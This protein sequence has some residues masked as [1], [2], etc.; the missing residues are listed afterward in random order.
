MNHFTAI[1][2]LNSMKMVTDGNLMQTIVNLVEETTNIEISGEE[3]KR[4]VIQRLK[5]VG[6]E[7][8]PIVAAT[9]GY[10]LNL[11]VEVAVAYIK[12]RAED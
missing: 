8:K 5:A 6:G 7:L 9:A 4:A 12:S 3:K 1:I 10:L 2:L 11:A